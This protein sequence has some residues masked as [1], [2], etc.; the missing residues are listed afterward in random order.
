MSLRTVLI[1]LNVLAF[2]VIAG[3]LVMRV[4]SLRRNPE[5]KDPQNLEP[6]L[7]DEEFEGRKLERV[8]G[9]SLL[10]T[11]VIAIAI[12]LYFLVEPS[13]EETAQEDFEERAVERGA[14]LF[15]NEQSENYDSTRSL[16]CADC[17][18][19]DAKGG[20]AQTTIQSE[21][22]SCD[23]TETITDETPSE[24]L[25][26]QVSWQAPPLD[27]ALLRYPKSQ[28]RDI[29]TFGRPG[30][31]MP[32]WGVRSQKGVL[33]E[34]G[35]DDL[36]AYIESITI[37]PEQAKKRFTEQLEQTRTDAATAVTDAREALTTA[38]SALAEASDAD[39]RTEAELDVEQAQRELDAA[40]AWNQQVQ[41]ASDGQLLFQLQCAR[42]HTK[43][44]SYYDPLDP[45]SL[46]PGPPGGG[47]YG[48]NLTGGAEERQFPGMT[49]PEDQYTFVA[50]GAPANEPYGVRGIASGR[51]PHFGD[52]L[53]KEQIEEIVEYERGL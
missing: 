30:T 29:I 32:A 11:A 4:I 8:L 37:T 12:P 17:H 48:P 47:A 14:V 5:P 22:P 7:T 2:A 41:Q 46:Q 21:D 39:A 38:Q 24:C 36:V 6:L 16:L 51:M 50:D 40:I 52:T 1:I 33:N 27:V 19:V 45:D 25:P 28:V 34:Q 49:G 26:K 9:L 35:I 42:C 31:P 43:G 3:I 10:S 44:W 23:L 18:G 20:S 53:T 13:R 15:A